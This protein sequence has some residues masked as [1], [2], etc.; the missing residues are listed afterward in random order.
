MKVTKGVVN[1]I[2]Y[3]SVSDKSKNRG[4]AFVEY[5]S[6]CSAAMARRKM[7]CNRIRLWGHNVVVD[8]AEPLPEVDEEIMSQV[9]VV[10][11][12]WIQYIV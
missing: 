8:W 10:S 2:V 11:R 12:N 6:H 3:P 7:S 9:C 4:F 5:D 1:V